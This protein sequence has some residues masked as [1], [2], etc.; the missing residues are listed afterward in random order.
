MVNQI[1]MFQ[2]RKS[3]VRRFASAKIGFFEKRN[4]NTNNEKGEEHMKKFLYLALAVCL[5]ALW[6]GTSFAAIT[7]TAHEITG[8]AGGSCAACHIPHAASGDRLWV[9][10][11]VSGA[12]PAAYGTSL[13]VL[14]LLE[15]G[16]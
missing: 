15:H 6:A 9:E 14:P 4:L 8:T 5:A 11:P 10:A 12:P 3:R 1:L 16:W 13:R 7:G 2:M